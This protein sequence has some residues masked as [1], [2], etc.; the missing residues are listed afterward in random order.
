MEENVYSKVK[1][2]P[3]DL[4]PVKLEVDVKLEQPHEDPPRDDVLACKYCNYNAKRPSSLQLHL[5]FH[6]PNVDKF[7]C[8]R[9]DFTTSH[10]FFLNVHKLKHF[11]QRHACKRCQFSAV[12][13]SD[14]REH[15]VQHESDV[16]YKCNDC[17]Y[18]TYF[19]PNLQAHILKHVLA[20]LYKCKLCHFKTQS[21][22][23]FARHCH[24]KHSEPYSI[25]NAR[26]QQ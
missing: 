23:Y 8:D 2:E 16:R 18:G 24:K 11:E 3:L 13:K 15:M 22:A 20:R 26:L 4:P 6:G 1:L 14:L 9:C 10:Q 19:K 5:Q 7:K 12:S 25:C 17:V 21:H